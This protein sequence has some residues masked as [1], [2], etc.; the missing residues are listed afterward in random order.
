VEKTTGKMV[1]LHFIGQPAADC[2]SFFCE[3]EG[4]EKTTFLWM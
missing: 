4:E 1:F 2:Y 3:K